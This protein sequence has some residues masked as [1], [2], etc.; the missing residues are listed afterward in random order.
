M[1]I[2]SLGILERLKVANENSQTIF[3]TVYHGDLKVHNVP[4]NLYPRGIG[5]DGKK[6]YIDGSVMYQLTFIFQKMIKDNLLEYD[7]ND[8]SN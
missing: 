8:V 6:E 7:Y 2:M 5:P 4:H 1:C 3:K